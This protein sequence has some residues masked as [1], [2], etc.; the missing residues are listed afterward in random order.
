MTMPNGRPKKVLPGDPDTILGE[1]S[2]QALADSELW[3]PATARS[4]SFVALAMAGEVG[5]LCNILKKVERGSS[6]LGDP[7]VRHEIAFETTDVLTYALMMAG[8]GGFDLGKTYEIKRAK[9][10]SRFGANNG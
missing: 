2:K 8:I 6:S 4:M 7:K 9:N 10:M 1:M 5:E 3:F